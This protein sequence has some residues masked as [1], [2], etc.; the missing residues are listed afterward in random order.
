MCIRDSGIIFPLFRTGSTWSKYSNPKFDAAADAAR[1]TLDEKKRMAEYKTAYE[2]LREDVP[3]LGLYQA[4]VSY[5][6]RK[7]LK[8]QPTPN[9]SLFI[10][11]MKWN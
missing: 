11:D 4:F 9:E 3:G 1:S 5:G 6:A 2:V 8:W 10:M 7:E